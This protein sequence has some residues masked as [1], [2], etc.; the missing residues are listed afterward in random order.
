MWSR[1]FHDSGRVPPVG[2]H[3]IA[4]APQAASAPLRPLSRCIATCG[5]G[6]DHDGY[7]G[8]G[9]YYGGWNGGWSHLGWIGPLFWPYAYGDVFYTALWPY[10]YGYVDPVSAY[11]YN[12]IY[13]GIFA[14]Y[15]Y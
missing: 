5:Y 6:T 14:P 3:A 13:E 4:G 10:Q 12:D 15:S 7:G 9:G 11:G 1:F 2:V 8:Y